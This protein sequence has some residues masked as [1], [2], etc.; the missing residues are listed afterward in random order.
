MLFNSQAAHS[1]FFFFWTR[2][3]CKIFWFQNSIFGFAENAMHQQLDFWD[4]KVSAMQRNMPFEKQTELFLTC[5]AGIQNKTISALKVIQNILAHKLKEWRTQLISDFELLFDI[6]FGL[7]GMS[8][9][10]NII[11]PWPNPVPCYA[12]G[13]YR[14]LH[15]SPAFS[16]N[17]F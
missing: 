16:Y 3:I 17:I 8:L 10:D 5:L 14:N 15:K 11:H 9:W 7:I 13:F 1:F 2:H 12:K 6:S 4:R